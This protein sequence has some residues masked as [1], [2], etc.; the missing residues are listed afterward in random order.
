MSATPTGSFAGDLGLVSLFDLGQLLMLNG[1]TGRLVVKCEGRRGYLFF[2]DGRIVNAVDDEQR[3]G[4]GAAYRIFSWKSGR[5]EFRPEPPGAARTILES[6]GALM[7]EAA[8]RI[9]EAGEPAGPTGGEAARLRDRQNAMEELRDV[10]RRLAREAQGAGEAAAEPAS[11]LLEALRD[12]DDRLLCRR[13]QMPRLF[14]DGSWLVVGEAPLSLEVFEELHARLLASGEG[15]ARLG[16]DGAGRGAGSAP[17]PVYTRAVTLDDGRMVCVTRLPQDGDEALW[18]RL[19]RL[20]VPDAG[21][22]DG[23]TERLHA[24]LDV[25]HG[26]VVVG[27]PSVDAAERLLNALVAV[28]VR[29]RGGTA[30]LVTDTPVYEHTAG[31]GVVL[32]ATSE[33]AVAALAALSPGIVAFDTVVPPVEAVARALRA[34]PL[35]V[36]GAVAPEAGA[37][38]ARWQ[39][40]L[41]GGLRSPLAAL[42]AAGPLAVVFTP[43]VPMG[44]DRIPFAVHAVEPGTAPA[45]PAPEMASDPERAAA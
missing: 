9:D 22:L 44:E 43:G 31:E 8:R 32:R 15:R 34:A 11:Q 39:A 19:A 18:I 1:A 29:R 41:G 20:P 6:P 21:Q 24:A 5:F 12:V 16:A 23:P 26:L 38:L 45:E 33:T 25:A 3:E 28:A 35:V 2:E 17:D 36:A 30:L 40:G 7:L 4:E 27:G 14:H 10:F 37:V 13:G 42:L